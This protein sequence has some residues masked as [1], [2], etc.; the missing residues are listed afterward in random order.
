MICKVSQGYLSEEYRPITS[1]I[2]AVLFLATPHRGTDLAEKL[3][4][5][6]S[7]SIL[8]HS[9]KAYVDELARNSPTIDELNESFRHHA[10]KLQIFSFYETLSTAI[11]PI[12]VMILEKNSSLLGYQNE[13][14]Q[15]LN[16]N[17]HDV[18]KYSD[19]N[20][21]NYKSV[22]GALRS[23]VNMLRT[24]NTEDDRAEKELES[25]QKWLGVNGP[26]EADMATLRSVRKSGTC[27]RILQKDEFTE[28]FTSPAPHILWANAP[29]GSGKSVHSCFVIDT[30]EERQTKRVYWFFKH[31]DTYKRSTA[32]ML[33][34]I[35]YQIALVDHIFRRALVKLANS[36]VHIL[37]A[38]SQSVWRLIFAAKL[39]AV[40]SEIF[41]VIDGLDEA[42]SSKVVLDL[43]SNIGNIPTG[44]RIFIA[45]RPLSPIVQ[46]IQRAKKR[47]K[48]TEIALTDNLSDIRLVA[49]D[50]ME[51]FPS[52]EETK[53]EITEEITTRSQGN[54][55]WASLV[56][57]RVTQCHRPEDV[58][59]VLRTTPDGMD[60]LYGRMIDA[61][62][63]LDRE[64]DK[65][66]GKIFLSW[67]MYANRPVNIDEITEPYQN[68]LRGVFDHKYT[69]GQVCGQ[70]VELNANSQIV[71]IHQTALEYL[72]TSNKLPFSLDSVEINEVLILKCLT[73]LHDH[74]LRTKIK[75]RKVP[76]F[77]T[78]ASL[79]WAF[80]LD[81]CSPE[82]DRVLE[83]LMKFFTG[84]FPL[85]W[86]QF[87][88][89]SG[90]LST[91]VAVSA[92]INS[93][94]RR[95][96]KADDIKPPAIRR[97][98]ELVFLET[99]ALDLLKMTAKFGRLLAEDSDIIYRYIPSLSPKSSM[100][101]QKYAK[102]P[103]ASISIS[104]LS[105]SDWDDCL[106]RISN[107]SDPALH[108][109]VSAQYLAVA[110]DSPNGKIQ[111]WNNVIF[112]EHST[113]DPGEPI[114]TIAF[115]QSGSLLACYGLNNTY[116]WSVED[117]TVVVKVASPYRQRAMAIEFG[118]HE[119][120]L[121]IA[122]DLRRVYRLHF[123]VEDPAWIA[124]DANLLEETSIPEG[125]FINSP[126]SVA[127]SADCSQ[128][129]VA[130]RGFPL[131][132]WNLDPPEM[133]A[134]DKRKQ[135][136]G[137]TTSTTWTGV[138]RVVWHPFNG[139]VLG[140]Y[141]DGNIFKWDPINDI[142][143]EVKQELDATP[144]EIVCSRNGSVFATSDVRGSVK[145]YD[146][147]QMVMMYKLTSDDIIK[148]IAFSPDSRRFYDLR[149][150]YCNVW[151]PNC[152]IRLVDTCMEPSEDSESVNSSE[153]ERT[154]SIV[155]DSEDICSTSIMPSEAH[156]D[157][158]SSITAVA[159][160]TGKQ[161]LLAYARD[162]GDIEIYDAARDQRHLVAQSTFGMNVAHVA[163]SQNGGHL[164]YSTLNGRI[165]IKTIDLRSK[166]GKVVVKT[167]FSETKAV[168]R[169]GIKQLLFD[170]GSQFLLVCGLEQYQILRVDTGTLAVERRLGPLEPS[171]KWDNHPK[172]PNL[173]VAFTHNLV[174]AISW[175]TLEVHYSIPLT[176]LE[177]LQDTGMLQQVP[178]IE[179]LLPSYHPQMYF[180]ISSVQ[181]GN[182]KFFN[183]HVLDTTMLS[184]NPANAS[185]AITSITIP[186]HIVERIE[187]P[188]SIMA[189]GR[190]VFLDE[191]LY[192][193]SAHLHNSSTITQHFFIPRDW[194]NSAGLVLCRVFP[195]G[196]F[197]CPSKGEMAVIS[198]DLEEQW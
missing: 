123:E 120:F 96:R 27:E 30:L 6:L 139:Q 109:A 101:Y 138:N 167:S 181:E 78:Y 172:D 168:N 110:N 5:I 22:R 127:I 188:V 60:K 158:K 149:G 94:I 122:T 145:I 19:P 31:G 190:L 155:P 82:S 75:Q 140:I 83:S 104:G 76:R 169:G 55:L 32:N 89:M 103:T 49:A 8:G 197:F 144:S 130:Y 50:E 77:L 17:H 108:V 183:Y 97:L 166:P 106:A 28:W 81:R 95:R 175:D 11:G 118:P 37:K 39:P 26:P 47:V 154:G 163:L 131:A 162:D 105:N 79:S 98:P 179:T 45:G 90:Q 34:S 115:S 196:T 65:D 29:P 80:H 64:E 182:S 156:A 143:E 54:F 119:S 132:V 107:S 184:E 10:T 180:V 21:A 61:I 189:D 113:F 161:R 99:W 128:L 67:A 141:R 170:R 157:T 153:R 178:S 71:L 33:R 159:M 42:D 147:S 88:A 24:S 7:S 93:F 193:C 176:L 126:S 59:R 111:L 187:Q 148:S 174:N 137:Q 9:P 15:P 1:K 112:Q 43:I 40:E 63:S 20:D 152:L 194:L 117:G 41:W 3:N 146:F 165:T 150:S 18:C 102:G 151:E 52:S 116:V 124:F 12:N 186:S 177:A 62:S 160:C 195:D 69:I 134:R 56:L 70:F 46:G 4:R 133:I 136:Q 73:A 48:I 38:D 86:I 72:R 114:W 58:K 74:S 135:K 125:A 68:E 100:L 129:A 85:P 44:I 13:T 16:A 35:A 185:C 25:V 121:I 91:L 192:V 87:L 171:V 142:R 92:S 14:P 191:D 173:L 164:A 53:Q 66:L 198:S 51:Y 36:G 23:V 57:K 84:D 2:K